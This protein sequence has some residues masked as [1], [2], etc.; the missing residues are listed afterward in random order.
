M[1]SRIE[2]EVEKHPHHE[3]SSKFS[4]SGPLTEP[5]EPRPKSPMRTAS[6]KSCISVGDCRNTWPTTHLSW[7]GRLRR[8][9][10]KE[11]AGGCWNMM[12]FS[13]FE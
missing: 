5:S 8:N 4:Y 1:A 10:V 11:V 12:V 7:V 6:R 3:F 13:R 2:D 9:C